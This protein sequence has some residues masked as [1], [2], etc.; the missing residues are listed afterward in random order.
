MLHAVVKCSKRLYSRLPEKT[1]TLAKFNF[2]SATNTIEEVSNKIDSYLNNRSAKITLH[3][4]IHRKSRL[5][6]ALSFGFIRDKQGDVLQFVSDVGSGDQSVLETMKKLSVE[7]SVAITGHA[8]RKET[9]GKEKEDAWELVAEEIQIL[10]ASN[11]DASRLE[12]LKQASPEDIPPQ[13]RYLQ[14][15]TPFYQNA[16]RTRSKLAQLV[17]KVLVENHDFVEIETPLLFKS[18]PEGAREFLVPTRAFD[19]FY[20]LPQSP[21]QYKQ[22]LMSSGFTRYFQMAKCFRDEDL[23]ADRQPEF[24]QI[25]LEMSFINSADQ[26]MKVVEDVVLNLWKHTS[27]SGTYHVN[28]KGNLQPIHNLGE[29]NNDSLQFQKLRYEEALQKYGIDKPDLRSNISFTS[30]SDFFV[31]KENPSFPVVEACVLKNAFEPEPEGSKKKKY[32]I[33]KS[34]IDP[35]NYNR[36]RPYVWAVGKEQGEKNG[37]SNWWYQTL[38]EKNI[39]TAKENINESE[40]NQLLNLEPGDIIAVSTRAELP[41]ENPTPLGKFRQLA[42]KEFPR[43]WLRPIENHEQQLV[44]DYDPESVTVGSWVVDFPLFNPVETSSHLDSPYPN[45]DFD[46]FESTHHPFTMCR[47]K[48]Y[49][50]LETD[51]LAVKGEHYDLVMNGVEVGGG[52]RRIHDPALQKF[53]FEEILRIQNHQQLFGHLVKALSMGCP[54]HA[55]LALGFD[56]L[57]AMIV[58][59]SSI[60]DVIAFPKNQ[61]GKDLVVDS[62]T[63]VDEQTLNDYHVTKF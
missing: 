18:T 56:R 27:K 46:K 36:R 23:R 39:I 37:N 16:L 60:R 63:S 20:A 19:S 55:G 5:R 48:D 2:P 47:S 21:Q 8:K 4:H 61:S 38:L 26:V 49:D 10:N 22:I 35:I 51:P 32:K 25:D 13:F 12:K 31:A 44:T 43:K 33:P 45:Y 34:L 53:V 17:R 29:N 11:L 1:S 6:A 7:D 28:S 57:C 54:P 24:T 9:V 58:G 52:S 62:P 15:R 3:G 59:S 14:L 30:L 42:I 40:L 41:Y 50:L